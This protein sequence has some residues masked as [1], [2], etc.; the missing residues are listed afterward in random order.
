MNIANQQLDK[1]FE[2]AVSLLCQHPHVHKE[3]KK[4]LIMHSLRVGMYLY[5]NDYPEDV[6]IGGLLHD[7]FE[8]TD[9]PEQTIKDEYGQKVFDIVQANTKNRD[10]ENVDERRKDYVDRCAAVGDEALIVKAVDVL[11]SYQFY[12]ATENQEEIDRSV[13]IAKLIVETGLKDKIVD[14]LKKIV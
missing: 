9:N 2:Q 8:W 6:V 1:K 14:E 7:M 11:D 5:N 12:Q 13:A 10:I 3:R 4:S